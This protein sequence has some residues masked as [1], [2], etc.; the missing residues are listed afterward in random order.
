MHLTPFIPL[1]RVRGGLKPNAA[2]DLQAER[3]QL[4]FKPIPLRGRSWGEVFDG[5][6]E[7]GGELFVT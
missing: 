5:K 2:E 3:K 7:V 1:S 4:V 6:Y